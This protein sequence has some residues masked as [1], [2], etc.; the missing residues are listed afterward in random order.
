MSEV[1]GSAAGSVSAPTASAVEESS[2]KQPVDSDGNVPAGPLDLAEVEGGSDLG[3]PKSPA[4]KL[5]KEEDRSAS[6][7][8]I[9]NEDGTSVDEPHAH[10]DGSSGGCAKESDAAD[11]SLGAKHFSTC[12]DAQGLVD[13]L[14][15][16]TPCSRRSQARRSLSMD[17]SSL[18]SEPMTETEA[19]GTKVAE[20]AA[21]GVSARPP[22]IRRTWRGIRPGAPET[23]DN[24]RVGASQAVTEASEGSRSGD[25]GTAV[26]AADSQMPQEQHEQH[27]HQHQQQQQQETQEEP[28]EQRSHLQSSASWTSSVYDEEALDRNHRST[29][30]S[31]SS[32]DQHERA[33]GRM[34]ALRARLVRAEALAAE[35]AR[36][37][38]PCSDWRK[39]AARIAETDEEMETLWRRVLLIQHSR[40]AADADDASL[41]LEASA[42][43]IAGDIETSTTGVAADVDAS[44]MGM[45]RLLGWQSHW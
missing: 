21:I 8:I 17:S 15:E 1:S 31:A 5:T 30:A 40:E 32:M 36:Q 4:N 7:D 2:S 23:D 43:G 3:L 38:R 13:P 22:F 39:R 10:T 44:K 27:Q 37:H 12:H 19:V 33:S 41:M 29:A 35:L 25:V 45:R 11:L 34:A 20:P 16:E 42:L 26:D 6:L 9:G 14:M 24:H 28:Q 18:A